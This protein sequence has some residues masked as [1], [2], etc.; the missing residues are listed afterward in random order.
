MKYVIRAV[1]Y[2]FYFSILTC[3]L[4]AV[5]ILIGSVEG[6]V[7]LIFKDGYKSILKIAGMF[8]VIAAAYPLV[9]FVR[10]D[11]CIRGGWE[12]NR[13]DIVAHM[14]S[15]GYVLESES[16]EKICFR[17]K[18]AA[19]KAARMW[20]DRITLTPNIMGFEFEGLRKDVVALVMSLESKLSS[21]PEE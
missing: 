6:N 13:A 21:S 7:D 10:R 4:I 11:A 19:R 5:L 3:L 15:K 12:A 18:S 14:E 17:A 20:E 9:G 8:A 1:K 2:F 16:P